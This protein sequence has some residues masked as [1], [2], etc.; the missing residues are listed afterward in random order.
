[1]VRALPSMTPKGD[2]AFCD[3]TLRDGEQTAGVAFSVA[4]KRAIARALDAAGVTEMEVGVAA[5]GFDEIAAMRA[6]AEDLTRAAPVVWCRL[7]LGDLD[8]A[9]HTGVKRVHFAVPVSERQLHGKLK[10]DRSWAL[11]NTAELVYTA[12]SRGMQVS[13]GA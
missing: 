10:A 9:H 12:T 11:Q 1:M 8:M 7:R 5:M 2:V 4:E 3:T 13:V 6:I